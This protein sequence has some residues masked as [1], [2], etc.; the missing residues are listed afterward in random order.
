MNKIKLTENRYVGENYSPF[1]I[2]EIGTNHNG[3]RKDE[4]ELIKIAKEAR[5]AKNKFFWS[6]T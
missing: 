1:I 3:N 6:I 2:A 4:F 5:I